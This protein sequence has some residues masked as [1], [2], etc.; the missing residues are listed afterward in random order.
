MSY[1]DN[2]FLK[3]A[4]LMIECLPVVF[5]EECFALKGGTAINLFLNNLPRLSVDIDLVYLP[6]EAFDESQI[7]ISNALMRIAKNLEKIIPKSKALLTKASDSLLAQKINL[8]FGRASVVIEPNFVIRGSLQKIKQ[9]PL[10]ALA[11]ELFQ[12]EVNIPV[13]TK[14][15]NYAGK[16]CAALER[17]HPRDLFDVKMFFEKSK[18]SD[19]LMALFIS[20]LL[21]SG[22]PIHEILF[23][24][25][26]NISAAY[27]KDFK[28]MTPQMIPL[29]A[30]WKARTQFIRAIH[31]GLS[32]SHKAFLITF[33]EGRPDWDL[34]KV[35]AASEFPGIQWKLKNIQTL[36]NLNPAKFKSQNLELMNKIKSI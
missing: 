21:C 9:L 8:Q 13:L 26:K 16:F 29:N 2:P 22:R 12:K 6:V 10:C 28:L 23:P 7:E 4:N 11:Q 36:K 31:L 24:T 15:E 20:Y 33:C 17:Q 18:M 14:N 3:Q 25:L 5:Q 1:K 32:D 34:L 19:E 30:L 35:S 27:E